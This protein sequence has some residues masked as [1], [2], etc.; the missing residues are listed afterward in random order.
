MERIGREQEKRKKEFVGGK[1]GEFRRVMV[2]VAERM[3]ED[4][5][6]MAGIERGGTSKSEPE[7]G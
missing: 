4:I 7:S 1:Q 2:G 6:R 3:I 5:E